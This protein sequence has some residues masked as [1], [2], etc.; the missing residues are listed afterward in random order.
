MVS[1]AIPCTYLSFYTWTVPIA[2]RHVRC[3]KI[4]E[5]K[6]VCPPTIP[7]PSDLSRPPLPL[8]QQHVRTYVRLPRIVA[9]FSGIFFPSPDLATTDAFA[10]SRF[11]NALSLAILS[12]SFSAI[13]SFSPSRH[14]GHSWEPTGR[15]SDFFPNFSSVRIR[16]SIRVQGTLF[17]NNRRDLDEV[18][19]FDNC[20][21]KRQG[22]FFF[23]PLFP[24][25]FSFFLPLSNPKIQLPPWSR[26]GESPGCV[27]YNARRGE[28]RPNRKLTLFHDLR[29]ITLSA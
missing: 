18:K 13:L 14:S 19:L 3:G 9:R 27:F 17:I 10:V 28:A 4:V 8:S 12:L 16:V 24:F 22:F 15:S 21:G 23:S 26:G 20:F 11:E 5:N 1:S 25:S 29:P 2:Y 7:C 6:L